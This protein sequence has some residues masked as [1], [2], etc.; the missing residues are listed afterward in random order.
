MREAIA[1]W[2]EGPG[3]GALR[4]QAVPARG[5]GDVLVRTLHTGISRGTEATVFGGHVPEREHE[6]MRAPFQRGDFPWPVEYGY[7]NVGEVEAGPDAL[8]G[9]TVFT[10]FPHQ[11]VFVVPS[12]AVVAVPD[13]VPARRAVLAGAVETAVDVLWDAAPLVGDRIAVVGAGMIGCCVARLARGIPGAEV[14][15]IDT[16]PRKG[17]VAARLGVDFASP[18]AASGDREVVIDT[19]GSDAGLALAL[20]LVVTE[21]EVV[22][23]S[24]FGDRPATLSLGADFHSRR[25]SIRSSQVG[26]VSPRRR[27]SRTTGD[28]LALA[29]DLLRDPAFDALLTGESSWRDLPRVM[30]AFADDPGGALCHT[31]DWRDA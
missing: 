6:R 7:L 17:E 22:E 18:A 26:T 23:A 15:L 21:G 9:R 24:W 29:L 8:R 10:L 28:R 11:S 16:D 5:D 25:L 2:V 4:T 1:F 13:G 31:V 14:T 27:G 3:I 19:S 12:A 20:E 30:A